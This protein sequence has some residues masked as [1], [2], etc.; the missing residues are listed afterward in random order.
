MTALDE[1]TK[2]ELIREIATALAKKQRLAFASDCHAFAEDRTLTLAG[3]S[4]E[5]L[6][7][8][9]DTK[10]SDGDVAAHAIVM[11]L[12]G[13][14]N[15]GHIADSFPHQRETGA[16]SIDYLPQVRRRLIEAKQLMIGPID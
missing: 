5:N 16:R 12:A 2:A 7:T 8:G 1:V 6:P 13:A 11:D 9:P 15:A 3:I 10:R 14:T 4:F